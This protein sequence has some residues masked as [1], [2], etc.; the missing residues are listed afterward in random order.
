MIVPENLISKTVYVTKVE[1]IYDAF[2]GVKIHAVIKEIGTEVSRVS[3]MYPV[4]LVM[5]QPANVKILPDMSAM[6]RGMEDSGQLPNALEQEIPVTAVF[7]MQ[8]HTNP[9]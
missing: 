3:R 2:P 9:V 7:Q 1:V 6:A 4:T 8:N 5:E